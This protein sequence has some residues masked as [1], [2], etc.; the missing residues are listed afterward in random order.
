MRDMLKVDK[1]EVHYGGIPVL[2]E[3]SFEIGEGELVAIV[4]ANGA[5]KSTTLK[6][7][8]GALN[9]VSGSIALE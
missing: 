9:P 5:G 4:G 7:V 8:V 6:T 2:H 1:I 3:V